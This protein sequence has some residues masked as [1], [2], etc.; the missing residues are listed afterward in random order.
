M[1]TPIIIPVH[2]QPSKPPAQIINEA[3]LK[4]STKEELRVA[5]RDGANFWEKRTN[6]DVKPLQ[7]VLVIYV[8][9]LF[10]AFFV[11]AADGKFSWREEEY[12]YGSPASYAFPTYGVGFNFSKWFFKR[13]NS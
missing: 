11:G 4:Y 1:N 9:V 2:H 8:L 12:E 5:F 13:N 10:V 6:F 7:I 3:S